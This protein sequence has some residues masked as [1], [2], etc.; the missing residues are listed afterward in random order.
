M[1][2]NRQLKLIT[3]LA[4]N[5]QGVKNQELANYLKISL[6]TLRL[7]ISKL[8]QQEEKELVIIRRGKG[9]FINN[10]FEPDAQKLIEASELRPAEKDTRSIKI[11]SSLLF[12]PSISLYELAD[13][14]Y[15]SETALRLEIQN[16]NA[17]FEQ[18]LVVVKNEEVSWSCDVIDK[19]RKLVRFIKNTIVDEIHTLNNI[20]EFLLMSL[21]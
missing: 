16:L 20:K 17:Q 14:L 1:L 4:Q 12:K 2:T 19:R 10:E 3:Y 15:L 11:V 9:Y 8:N 21:I 18:P 7:E 5:P 6:R 13:I